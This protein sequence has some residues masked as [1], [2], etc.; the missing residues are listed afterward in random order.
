MKRRQRRKAERQLV[1]VADG[2]VKPLRS[3][4]PAE[5]QLAQTIAA[6]KATLIARWA[7]LLEELGEDWIPRTAIVMAAGN[8]AIGR[9][10]LPNATLPE[11]EAEVA[12]LEQ[13]LELKRA[14]QNEGRSHE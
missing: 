11:W 6:A 2:Q 13:A 8:A 1:E 10:K 9:G 5:V 14:T 3:C 4:S 7:Q 12:T